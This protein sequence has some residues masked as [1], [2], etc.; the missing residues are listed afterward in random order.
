M[1]PALR[2]RIPVLIYLIGVADSERLASAFEPRPAGRCQ[3][4]IAV[5]ARHGGRIEPTNWPGTR[6]AY[7]REALRCLAVRRRPLAPEETSF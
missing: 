2:D 1:M 6:R 4:G 7:E 5:G 3:L